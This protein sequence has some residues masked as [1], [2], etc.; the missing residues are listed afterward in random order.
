MIFYILD[1]LLRVVYVCLWVVNRFYKEIVCDKLTKRC[2]PRISL[3][4]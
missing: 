4:A 2:L 3:S 1:I